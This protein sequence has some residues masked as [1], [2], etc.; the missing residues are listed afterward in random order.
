MLCHTATNVHGHTDTPTSI[1]IFP[2]GE[3]PS[4]ADPRQPTMLLHG[5]AMYK[6]TTLSWAP[7][8]RKGPE[9]TA[10]D[11]ELSAFRPLSGQL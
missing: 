5:G 1:G 7:A 8:R 9:A 2:L 4:L 3:Q 6:K 11:E 10:R